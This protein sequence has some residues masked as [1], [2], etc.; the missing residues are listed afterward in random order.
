MI[1]SSRG[2]YPTKFRHEYDGS[3]HHPGIARGGG[4]GRSVGVPPPGQERSG[5]LSCLPAIALVDHRRRLRFHQR[6]QRADRGHGGYCLRDG[7]G[8]GQLGVV[9]PPPVHA[10]HALLH[11]VV[12]QES[13][14]NGAGAAGAKVR[15][16]LRKHLQ[17]GDS[18]GLRLHLPGAG[19]VRRKPGPVPIDRCWTSLSCSGRS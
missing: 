9:H 17:L 4:H 13:H 1:R 19:S 5:L 7:H 15:S 2:K 6:L 3:G 10:A 11:P 12:S 16:P 8:R 18:G 14:Y